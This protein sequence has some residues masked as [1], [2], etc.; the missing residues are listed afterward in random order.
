MR[1]T[2]LSQ[3][4]H[5][6]DFLR[7]FALLS[8]VLLHSLSLYLEPIDG[9]EPRPLAAIAFIWIHSWR[10][11]LFMLLAGFFTCLS[12]SKRSAGSYAINR[13]LRL[14][15]PIVLLWLVIPS[16]DETQSP[17]VKLPELLLWLIYDQSFTL[18][19]DH[20]W[21]LY[22]LLIFYLIALVM[23]F[24][25][26]KVFALITGIKINFAII[27][28]IWLP[29]LIVLSPMA[30]PTGGIFSEIP[31]TFGELKLG[32]ML[33]MLAFFVIGMQLFNSQAFIQS[34]Q[35]TF[36]LALS[37]GL[38][39]I[40]PVALMAWGIMK[41]DPF[42][43][44]SQLELWI[45]NSF[46]ALATLLLVLALIGFATR[47]IRSGGALLSLLVRLSYPIYVF[48]LVFVYAFGGSLL[49]AGYNAAIVVF[50]SCISGL[51][52]SII[53]YYIFICYTPL[54][55]IFNGYKNSKFKVSSSLFQKIT[56]H[57]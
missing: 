55:W 57:L 26:P 20:L 16:V 36:F 9:S 28:C 45:V 49:L 4:Y 43:F 53:V 52:G 33:F 23:L 50:L 42:A 6:L 3:R 1:D 47:I 14:G 40:V 10:M 22:Y 32:S 12:M 51:L 7:A 27:L 46:S 44:S 48:H 38:F 21:F 17:M 13:V 18:R 24:I 41:D 56:K 25:A 34:I 29:I 54:D 35:R 2:G 15:G 37:I 30:R 31:L 11:P 39:S 5:N 19:L 8:G